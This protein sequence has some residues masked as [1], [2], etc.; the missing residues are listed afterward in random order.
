ML[1]PSDL[2]VIIRLLVA[3]V[4]GGMIGLEREMHDKPAGFR[5]HVL[6][7]V[8]SALYMIIS[9]YFAMEG[10]NVDPA[11]IAAQVVTGIGFLGAGTIFRSGSATK[12]LTTA[13]SLWAVAGI[14]LA[15]GIGGVFFRV[16]LYAT[17]I[18][19]SALI[20]LARFESLFL[21]RDRRRLFTLTMADRPGQL[22]I[23]GTKLGDIGVNIRNVNITQGEE[24]G[25]L[26]V[27]LLLSIPPDFSFD[28]V[29][30]VIRGIE[31][32]KAVSWD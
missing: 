8:G 23:V 21:P 18:V 29:K 28:D 3:A 22:G 12:G 17:V 20:L 30:S 1:A 25:S 32:V 15:V 19:L 4:L 10:R 31:G 14:G 13:A 7:S 9:Q 27:S 6:V 26:T 5:T 11:R 24:D 2:S 16:A